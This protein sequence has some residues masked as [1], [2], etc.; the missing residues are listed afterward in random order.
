[1]KTRAHSLGLTPCVKFSL[2]PQ[3]IICNYLYI[4]VIHSYLGYFLKR[5]TFVDKCS[6]SVTEGSVSYIITPSSGRTTLHVVYCIMVRDCF[7]NIKHFKQQ[8]KI[9]CLRD[10]LCHNLPL[11]CNT[12]IIMAR[13]RSGV[14]SPYIPI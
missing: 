14:V 5:A 3:L 11:E 6:A 2:M 12:E 8:S 1:M 9:V 13:Q 4:V 10:M 7:S